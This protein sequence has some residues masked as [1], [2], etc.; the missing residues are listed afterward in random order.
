[1]F[2]I[3]CGATVGEDDAFCPECGEKIEQEEKTEDVSAKDTTKV[4]SPAPV[5]PAP[6]KTAVMTPAAGAPSAQNMAYTQS[7]AQQQ[8]VAVPVQAVPQMAVAA[9]PA[10]GD[11]SGKKNSTLLTVSIVVA[12]VVILIA[13][14]LLILTIVNP[15]ITPW[16]GSQSSSTKS[17]QSK[18]SSSSKSDSDKDSDSSS[19]NSDSSSN[20]SNS[21]S[22]S[23]SG[24]TT[25]KSGDYVI[26][27]SASRTLTSS[28]V[29]GLSSDEICI[30][31]NEIWARH[32]RKFKNN[33][34]QSYFNQKSWYTPSIE[35]DNFLNVYKP[36][37]TENNNASF[38]NSILSSRGYD[39]NK[40]HPN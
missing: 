27:D 32:G 37:D 11:A 7:A 4:I 35:A 10:S 2:C 17:E 25:S 24:S 18:D 20:S 22:G 23:S 1:M 15:E 16:G 3:K 5:P 19:S 38:L 13:G 39:V 28:D 33:W 30:A 8:Y 21:N 12:T 6:D 40:A 34:L 29:S 31:Q 9:A 26:S 36:S 14:V